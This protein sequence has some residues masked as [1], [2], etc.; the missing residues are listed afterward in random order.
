MN[1]TRRVSSPAVALE[2]TLL[3]HGVPTENSLQLF[4]ELGS[5][6]MGEGVN[7]ALIGLVEGR[8][9]AGMTVDELA[10][11]LERG[12]IPKA[13]TSN[14]GVLQHWGASAATTV[15]ATMEIASAAGI[16][17]FA[18]G[19]LGGVHQNLW[20]G[21]A[22]CN[23]DISSDLAAMTRFPVAVVASGVKSILDVASTRELLES[24][25]VCVI[26]YQ[27]DSFP[28]FY[29]RTSE[30]G[31]DARMDSP[32]EVAGFVKSELARACRGILIV[33]PI[34][35]EHEIDSGDFQNWLDAA[36]DE[37]E[38]AG[39]T[40]R[41]VTPSILASLHR[42]SNGRTLE[43]NIDLVKSNTLL[44]SRIAACLHKLRHGI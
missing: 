41:G 13:N 30:A 17:V 24:L 7:P 29:S 6:C 39:A 35:R 42:L 12:S 26:G 36:E 14:L 2:T 43:A 19:G 27:T 37:A 3:V 34:P 40:G 11:M 31:V 44:A 25:G 23:L 10:S 1:V 8:P 18:T 5:L 33:N 9:I 22:T 4:Q 32:E 16:E 15:S 28:A 38:E 21:G 20:T